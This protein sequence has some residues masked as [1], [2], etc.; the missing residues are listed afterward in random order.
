MF[1]PRTAPQPL[2]EATPVAYTVLRSSQ[3]CTNCS[4]LHDSAQVML[5]C[6]MPA[7]HGM[8]KPLT[9]MRR[10]DGAPQYNLPVESRTLEAK[11]IPFCHE[12]F[13][14]VTLDHLPLPP[15][16]DTRILKPVGKFGVTLSES[17]LTG[18]PREQA[19]KASTSQSRKPSA[20]DL[21]DMLD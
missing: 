1:T 6:E 10:L 9:Q 18:N 7:R 21:L 19:P 14:T 13:D 2:P 16:Q 12:C 5:R 15:Q 11:N 17:P 4:T 3:Y 8:G 20:D